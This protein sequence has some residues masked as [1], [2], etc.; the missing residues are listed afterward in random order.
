M[1]VEYGVKLAVE[2]RVEISKLLLEVLW[3]STCNSRAA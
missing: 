3:D 1:G 2:M